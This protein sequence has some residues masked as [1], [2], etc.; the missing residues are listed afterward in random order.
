MPTNSPR[1]FVTLE[2]DVFYDLRTYMEDHHFQSH[3]SAVSSFLSQFLSEYFQ[4]QSYGVTFFEK[5]SDLFDVV[6]SDF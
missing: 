5:Y 1:I 2:P 6:D 4:H 3:S